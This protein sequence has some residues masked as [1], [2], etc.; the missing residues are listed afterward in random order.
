MV[1]SYGCS[2]E[3]SLQLAFGFDSAEL[4][5]QDKAM[6][7]Q[8]I[9]AMRQLPT[10]RGTVAGYTDSRGAEA[11]NQNLSER[12]ANAVKDYL[13][14]A[15]LTDAEFIAVG[16]GEANPVGDNATEEGRAANRRVVLERTDCN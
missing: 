4:T 15:N 16:Y 12:R 3:I 2:C 9:F 5:E 1:D 10:I 8:L 7:D 14:A 13:E 11:Y 6:L